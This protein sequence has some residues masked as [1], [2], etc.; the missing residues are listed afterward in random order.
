MKTTA[1]TLLAGIALAATAQAGDNYSAKGSVEVIPPAPTCLWTWIAG[2]SAGE[3]AGDWDEEIY[4]FHVGVE[5]TCSDRACTHAYFLEVGFTEKDF[6]ERI[7]DPGYPSNKRTPYADHDLTIEVMPI[8]LNY[9]CECPLGGNFNWYIG[10][11]AGIAIV[12]LDIE[13]PVIDDSDDDTAFYAHI[14]AGITYNITESFEIFGG[15]RLVFMDDVFD[16]EN[17]IDQSPHYEV[18]VRY[19]F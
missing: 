3:V 17:E 9:K 15:A 7:M 4:T 1:M 11:G 16:V 19:N 5:R 10:A 12:D 14:F 8:T 2:G 6:D 18:G 13:G